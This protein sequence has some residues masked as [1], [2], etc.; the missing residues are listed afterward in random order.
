[1]FKYIIA[2]LFILL[3]VGCH[4]CE[5]DDV[6]FQLEDELYEAGGSVPDGVD[7][8][9]DYLFR[10][11]ECGHCEMCDCAIIDGISCEVSSPFSYGD[12]VKI[13]TTVRDEDGRVLSVAEWRRESD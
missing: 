8:K 3:M 2:M 9:T 10:G 5:C 11:I 4:A 6:L 1:M 7:A 13:V 12:F